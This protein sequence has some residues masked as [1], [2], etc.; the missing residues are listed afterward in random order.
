MQVQRI[1]RLH[2][3]QALNPACDPKYTDRD[4][5]VPNFDQ[6]VS[7]FFRKQQEKKDRESDIE[8]SR[9]DAGRPVW[10]D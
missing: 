9:G 1:V 2:L 6:G 7:P 3:L 5:V 4:Y 10:P 8:K